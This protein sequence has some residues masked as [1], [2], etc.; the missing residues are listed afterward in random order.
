METLAKYGHR[1]RRCHNNLKEMLAAGQTPLGLGI[2]IPS[3]I[4]VELAAVAGL[5]YIWIDTEHYLFNPETICDLVR[6]ADM[7]GLATAVRTAQTS[8]ILPL[9]DFGV[10]GLTI[11]HVRSAA[12]AKDLVDM[13]KYAPVGRRGF[14]DGM[15]GCRYGTMPIREYA[16][17]IATET[18]LAVMIEDRE[19]VENMEAILSTPGID[20]VAQGPGDLSQGMGH[21]GNLNHPEVLEMM[22]KIRDTADRTGV[23]YE[24][25]G[26]PVLLGMDKNILRDRLRELVEKNRPQEM[27]K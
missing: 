19:G 10:Q 26:A 21:F 23:K 6:A 16:E 8:M 18:Y 27:S 13:V 4:I 1:Q 11:P 7:C 12:Q 24:G 5:D 14:S 20:F 25:T 3:P 2:S 22:Q 17:E 9:L 15:R